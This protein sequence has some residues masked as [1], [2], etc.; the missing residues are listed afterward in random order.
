[1]LLWPKEHGQFLVNHFLKCNRRYTLSLR[2]TLYFSKQ[3][4]IRL[5]QHVY[6]PWRC[7]SLL[8]RLDIEVLLVG[9][10]EEEVPEEGC[11]EERLQDRI[12]VASVAD[13]VQACEILRDFISM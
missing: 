13:V 10:C 9:V 7:H 4:P 8:L 12:D 1:M 3:F 11:V 2:L 5:C 6:F